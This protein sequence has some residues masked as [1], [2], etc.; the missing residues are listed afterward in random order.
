MKALRLDD[1]GQLNMYDDISKPVL[2]PGEV[3]VRV[4]AA[5]I[6][7]SDVARVYENGAH[8]M[9]LIIGHEFSGYIEDTASDEDKGLIG[10]RVGVFP[11][12]PCGKCPAC[13][14]S[15]YEMCH[16]YD[17]LG[18]RR[19][20]GYAEYVA[21][22]KWNVIMLP[23]NISYENAAMLEPMAV[24]VHAIRRQTIKPGMTVAVSGLGTIGQLILMFLKEMGIDNIIAIGNKASQLKTA[25][26]LGIDN[27]H[28]INIRD[29]QPQKAVMNLTDAEGVDMFFE[30]VGKNESAELA[31]ECTKRG[32]SV[33]MVGNPYTDM[34]FSKEVYWKILRN[35][36]TI[37]GTWN[38][39][40]LGA[41]DFNAQDDDWNY[42]ISKMEEGAINPSC[43]IT[44]NIQFEELTKALE[45][46]RDKTEDYIKVM[47]SM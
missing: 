26:I 21:V 8:N 38:S 17:Y 23:D 37:K 6:C 14:Q 45:M 11:L 28:L 25:S 4:K 22:P 44:H 29:N 35:Q 5:G 16:S 13:R 34:Y 32:G 3:L 47:V 20:G 36:L 2:K 30:C 15:Q 33:C 27:S 40:Y 7:G 12:I 42:C 43:L 31:I 10:K 46:M 18:S 41:C 19:D 39:S 9:P 24:A 1:I